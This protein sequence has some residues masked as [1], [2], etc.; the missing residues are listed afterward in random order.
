M[1]HGDFKVYC[2]E[3]TTSCFP[4]LAV[5]AR[6]VDEVKEEIQRRKGI[7]VDHVIMTSDEKNATWW[8]DVRALGWYSIDHSE[9]VKTLGVW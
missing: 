6:R 4:S 3:N 5:I 9:T 8:E 1:R 2:G 7:S